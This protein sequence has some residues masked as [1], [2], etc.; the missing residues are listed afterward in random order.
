[1]LAN[2]MRISKNSE[3]VKEILKRT[4]HIPKDMGKG[5]K[6]ISDRIGYVTNW[7][8][9]TIPEEKIDYSL[10]D[11]QGKAVTK[12]I[13]ELDAKDWSEEE[14]YARLYAIPKEEGM[15]LGKFFEAAYVLLLNSLRG[16]RLAQFIVAV[17]CQKAAD[18]MKGRMNEF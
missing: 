12:L 16:P 7:I 15:E 13:Y 4:G 2:L 8:N 17:G 1:M 11:V 10:S 6:E 5:E 18:M 9:D 3:V 14:L